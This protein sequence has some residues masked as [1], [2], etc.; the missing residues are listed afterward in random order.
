MTRPAIITLAPRPSERRWRRGLAAVPVLAATVLLVAFGGVQAGWY[1][2]VYAACYLAA[3]LAL[4]LGM[5]G[6]VLGVWAR[7]AQRPVLLFVLL[8]ALLPLAQLGLRTTV[9]RAATETAFLHLAAAACAFLL[10]GLVCRD[11]RFVRGLIRMTAAAAGILALWGIAQLFL[12]PYQIFGIVTVHGA[13]PMGPFVDR[14]H[15]A[16]CME[17]LLPA[18]LLLSLAG[19][20]APRVNLKTGVGWGMVVA[21]GVAAVVVSTSRAGAVV[22]ALQLGAAI[23]CAGPFTAPVLRAATVLGLILLLY[24]SA[25]GFV[26]LLHRL[27]DIG[28]NVGGRWDLARSSAAMGARRPLLGFGAGTW[29]AV[30]PR[31]AHF[32]DGQLY[33]YAHN[34][35]LQG[36][37]EAGLLGI[38]LA[39]GLVWAAFPLARGPF[40]NLASP[41]RFGLLGIAGHAVVDFPWHIPAL[42]LLTACWLQLAISVPPSRLDPSSP[43]S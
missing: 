29:A 36:W 18:A 1:L 2:P 27:T 22:I 12:T 14:D 32:E 10:M 41:F 8:L 35:V 7:G 40:P 25:T 37:A 33:E 28:P 16:A 39:G 6:I 19:W 43:Q 11:A 24:V 23:V 4:V 31:F 5:L 42:L 26:P 21:V 20:T 34:E 9:D 15:F 3:A 13:L 38:L 30:Y 17:L